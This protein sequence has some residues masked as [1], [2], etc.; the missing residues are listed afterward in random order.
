MPRDTTPQ[1]AT[2]APAARITRMDATPLRPAPASGT[3]PAEPPAQGPALRDF[4]AGEETRLRDLLAFAMA[5]EA[6]REATPAA[7]EGLR[8]K[9]EADLHAHA[10]RLLHNQVETIRHQAVQEH[11][12]RVTRGLSFSRVLIA[13]LVAL[14][15]AA[16]LA[17][18]ATSGEPS[19][20]DRLRDGSAQ[21][22]ARLLTGS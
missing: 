19:F 20:L 5:A 14:A 16:V 11:F 13:N 6:G 15:V 7:I 10:F 18:L 2:A 3:A 8:Q 4:L 9:A 1:D 22:L 12:S 17:L 21:L